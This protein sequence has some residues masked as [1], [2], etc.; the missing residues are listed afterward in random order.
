MGG[1]PSG[2][3]SFW[4]PQEEHSVRATQ[5]H[6]DSGLE[7][8][9]KCQQ[10]PQDVCKQSRWTQVLLHAAPHRYSGGNDEGVL[11]VYCLVLSLAFLAGHHQGV[12]DG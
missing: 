7:S 2:S 11:L 8:A 4:G 6:A 3:F 12:W 5:W 1:P 9:C 10:S